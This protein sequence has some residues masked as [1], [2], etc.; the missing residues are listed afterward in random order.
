MLIFKQKRKWNVVLNNSSR[1][2][3]SKVLSLLH[4]TCMHDFPRSYWVDEI[5]TMVHGNSSEVLALRTKIGNAYEV[6]L[7]KESRT[8]G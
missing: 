2:E 6:K 4:Y 5:S 7:V 8:D 3:T 1:F